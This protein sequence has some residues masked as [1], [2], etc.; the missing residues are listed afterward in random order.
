MR[1]KY[2]DAIDHILAQDD[3]VGTIV[4]AWDRP[5]DEPCGCLFAP[6][7]RLS[8]PL[9]TVFTYATKKYGCLTEIKRQYSN[10]SGSCPQACTPEMTEEILK[11]ERIP[12]SYE[13][14]QPTREA[15]M[16]FAEYQDKVDD[17]YEELART[18]ALS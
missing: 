4:K 12:I 15:L 5:L 11:D 14:I 3:I 2:I 1:Q 17:Y 6:A 8:D 18:V 9:V 13:G 7:A 16:V 10:H